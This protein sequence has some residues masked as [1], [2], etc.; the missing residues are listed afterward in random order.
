MTLHDLK[1][2]IHRSITRMCWL[3]GIVADEVEVTIMPLE[4]WHR[5]FERVR[6]AEARVVELERQLAAVEQGKT[7]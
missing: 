4:Q 3:L 7:E 2:L 6:A 5:V 1:P